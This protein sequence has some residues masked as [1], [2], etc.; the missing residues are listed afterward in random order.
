MNLRAALYALAGRHDLDAAASQRLIALAAPGAEPPGLASR[1]PL[2][3]AVAAAALCGLGLV[4]WVAANWG[5]L[6]RVGRFALLQAAVVTTA[7]AAALRPALRAPGGLAALLAI[8]AL[9]A[10]FG[11][12][13]QTGVDAWQ[14]FALW[15]ALALPLALAARSDVLWAPWALVTMTAIALWARTHTGHAWRVDL[16]DLPAH[17]IALAL[18]LAVV[19]ALGP[20]LRRLTGAGAWSR[21]TAFTLFVVMVVSAGIGALFADPVVPH[22][23]LALAVLAAGAALHARRAGFDVYAL[24]AAALGLDTL[25]VG[26][27]ARLLLEDLDESDVAGSL[28]LVG[29]VAAGLLA[30]S[31][32]LVLQLAR[33]HGDAPSTAETPARAAGPSATPPATGA[34]PATRDA[35]RNPALSKAPPRVV[36]APAGAPPPD[37]GAPDWLLQARGSGLLPPDADL[38]GA[39]ARPWPVVLLTA[40]GAWLAAPPILAS[41]GALLGSWLDDTVGGVVVGLLALAA[42][43]AVL[44]RPGQGLFVEQL[45]VPL[46]LTGGASLGLALFRELPTAAA[47]ALLGLLALALAWALTQPWLRTLLGAAACLL[48]GVAGGA[49]VAQHLKEMSAL[50]PQ[51]GLV[52]GLLAIWLGALWWQQRRLEP[53]GRTDHAAWLEAVATGWL[54]MLLLGLASAAGTSFLVGGVMGGFSDVAGVMAGR[55]GGVGAGLLAAASCGLA[56]AAAGVAS[57][58]WPTLRAWPLAGAALVIAALAAL[59]PMLGAALLA[60]AVT[61]TTGRQGLAGAAAFVAAWIVGAFYYQLAWPLTDKAAA[62]AAAGVLIGTLALALRRGPGARGRAATDPAPAAAS[63]RPG[64]AGPADRAPPRAPARPRHWLAPWLVA[65]A[66]AATLGVVNLGIR[67]KETLIAQGRP[68]YVE[69]APVDPRSLMQ[70]DYMRLAFRLPDA[71]ALD[72]HRLLGARRPQ[73]AARLDARGVATLDRV[74]AHGSEPE[75]GELRIELTPKDGDWVLVTDGWFFAEGEAERWAKARYGEFRVEADGRALLVG[76]ADE[77]LR[78][79]GPR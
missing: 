9:F 18:A 66:A 4:M 60:L 32:K 58:A 50:A 39:S 71:S 45:A 24:S 47:A 74:L 28:M 52:H 2:G 44:R 73:V 61:L 53:S 49:L 48:A 30:G 46:L 22:Y 70:G 63:V 1:L 43:V 17:A 72:A 76:M 38:A 69:L 16:R 77:A 13:Y 62:L 12:T 29:L 23:W 64:R 33:R 5:E 6:G 55:Q 31:V 57:R 54:A 56:L 59:M 27:L 41:L 11:Q 19:L 7:A 25:L 78:P 34:A 14:F 3:L 8:G 15:A 51:W 35:A 65:L 26:G 42:A 20:W 75:P 36:R 21:R 10:S 79:I 67:D 40:L 37:A 68:V